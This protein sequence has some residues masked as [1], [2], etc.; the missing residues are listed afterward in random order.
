[1]KIDQWTFKD[2]SETYEIGENIIV[3][4]PVEG[5]SFDESNNPYGWRINT[6]V[7][8]LVMCLV[9]NHLLYYH[10]MTKYKPDDE[11]EKDLLYSKCSECDCE[12]HIMLG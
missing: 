11:N 8:I 12:S 10:K 7:N 6:T 9:C 4:E 5:Y 1:M 2:L 3:S